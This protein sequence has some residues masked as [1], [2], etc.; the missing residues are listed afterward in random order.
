MRPTGTFNHGPNGSRN[1][2]GNGVIPPNN[3]RA[4]TRNG[5]AA[6]RR[7]SREW[8][9]CE[10]R[11]LAGTSPRGAWLSYGPGVGGGYTAPVIPGGDA[12]G[13]QV[14]QYHSPSVW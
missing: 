6:G 7:D 12:M 3:G 4:T 9:W 5:G 11:S 1:G 14:Q 8:K 2:L 10:E 13:A